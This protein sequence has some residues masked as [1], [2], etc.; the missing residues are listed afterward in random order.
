MAHT[1]NR[2]ESSHRDRGP[3]VARV[4]CSECDG[5][6]AIAVV[7]KSPDGALFLVFE[8]YWEPGT[9]PANQH[10]EWGRRVEVYATRF[11]APRT[12]EVTCPEHGPRRV[13]GEA[14]DEAAALG[15]PSKP[16]RVTV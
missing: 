12:R 15:T 16:R 11:H 2:V 9:R 13:T 1:P 5:D 14:V 6:R 3:I 7:R 10:R 8:R 4:I